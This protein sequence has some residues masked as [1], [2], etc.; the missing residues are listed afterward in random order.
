MIIRLVYNHSRF[1]RGIA[2]LHAIE[3]GFRN[4]PKVIRNMSVVEFV[5]EAYSEASDKDKAITVENLQTFLM[6][7][8]GDIS[9]NVSASRDKGERK[10]IL[11]EA[12]GKF[13]KAMKRTDRREELTRIAQNAESE[14]EKMMTAKESSKK[15]K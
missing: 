15:N 7:L 8:S 1:K 5:I 12:W 10:R 11:R 2:T 14:W 3:V 9:A 6:S 4:N 13:Q